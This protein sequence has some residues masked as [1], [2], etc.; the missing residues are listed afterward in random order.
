MLYPYKVYLKWECRYVGFHT[1]VEAYTFAKI[2]GSLAIVYE[3]D[4]E[5]GSYEQIAYIF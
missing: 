2:S 5:T 4:P 3:Y 1:K